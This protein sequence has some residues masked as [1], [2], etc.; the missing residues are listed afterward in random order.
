MPAKRRFF[1]LQAN[2]IPARKFAETEIES[3]RDQKE[4]LNGHGHGGHHSSGDVEG[5]GEKE[6]S[7]AIRAV[8]T[9]NVKVG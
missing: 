8:E 3:L 6:K 2:K 7:E 5:D 4:L 9:E 1:Y